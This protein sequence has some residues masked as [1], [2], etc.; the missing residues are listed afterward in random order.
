MLSSEEIEK[1]M[2]RYNYEELA[3]MAVMEEIQ[4]KM[5]FVP[6]YAMRVVADTLELP[7]SRVYAL[8]SFYDVSG[9]GELVHSGGPIG[10]RPPE[11]CGGEWTRDG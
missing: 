3:L 10:A 4:G 6:S 8:C 5:G 2:R 1:I 7:L 11:L 9:G